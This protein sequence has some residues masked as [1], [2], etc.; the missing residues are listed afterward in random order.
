M[1]RIVLLSLDFASSREIPVHAKALSREGRE[2]AMIADIKHY[3]AMKLFN[4]L[5]KFFDQ[6]K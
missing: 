2:E 5:L 1:A 3:L 6:Y 4:V